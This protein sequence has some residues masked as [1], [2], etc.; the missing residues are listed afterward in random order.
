MLLR[1]KR[2]LAFISYFSSVFVSCQRFSFF[3]PKRVSV[4]VFTL[5]NTYHQDKCDE[6]WPAPGNTTTYG[7]VTVASQ[8]ESMRANFVVRTFHL[9]VNGVRKANAGLSLPLN[10]HLLCSFYLLVYLIFL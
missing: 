7:H 9:Q 1:F 4:K 3:D 6:Y 8:E 10:C 2:I 5:L